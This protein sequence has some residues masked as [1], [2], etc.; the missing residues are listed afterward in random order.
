MRFRNTLLLLLVLLGLGGYVYWVELPQ[1]EKEEKKEKLVEVEADQVTEIVL[2]APDREIALV[3]SDGAWRLIRPIAGD[4][5]ESTVKAILSTLGAAEVKKALDEEATDLAPFGLDKPNTTIAMKAGDR[6]LPLIRIG[7]ATPVGN[8]AYALRGDEKKVLLTTAAVRSGVDRTLKDLRNKTILRF[9]DDAVRKVEIVAPEGKSLTLEADGE[10]WR[11]TAPAA[12]PADTT[13]VRAYLSTL[14]AL[15]ATDFADDGDPAAYGLAEPST[16][17]TVALADGASQSLL[18]GGSNDKKE[19]WVKTSASPVVYTVGEWVGRDLAKPLADFRDK[20]LLRFEREAAKSI[21]V[22]RKDGAGFTLTRADDGNWSLDKG[23][24][25][26]AQ[27]VLAQF[28][29][30]VATLKGYEIVADGVTDLAPWGLEP[31]AMAIAVRGADGADLGTMLLGQRDADGEREY[32]ASHAGSGTVMKVRD[33]AYTRLDKPAGDLREK[34][35]AAAAPAAE[36][37]PAD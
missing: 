32:V 14:R 29:N 3:K 6:A 25:P 21:V 31:P 12:Y 13:A 19:V 15:R 24:G 4:A 11:I 7:K 35:P 33:F 28:F 23:D 2:T 26:V 30:D 36:A 8:S 18:V 16:R 27:S 9:T 22:T 34:P 17:V 37:P 10:D 5:D 1:A 20:S